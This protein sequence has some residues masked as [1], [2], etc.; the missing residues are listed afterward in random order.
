M[1]TYARRSGYVAAIELYVSHKCISMRTLFVMSARALSAY[2]T[3]RA[4]ITKT[5]DQEQEYVRK[6][7]RGL[8]QYHETLAQTLAHHL[9]K[10]LMI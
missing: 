2:T 10:S 9:S 5:G 7:V 8:K 6:D 1:N 4:R 3:M